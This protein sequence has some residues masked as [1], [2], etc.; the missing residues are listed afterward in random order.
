[1]RLRAN[2]IA[3]SISSAS[4]SGI[5]NRIS[6]VDNSAKTRS[7]TSVTKE[8]RRK[9]PAS[10]EGINSGMPGILYVSYMYSDP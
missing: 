10:A 7:S 8:S 4:R 9:P 5:S 6:G 1:M 3:A 2:R